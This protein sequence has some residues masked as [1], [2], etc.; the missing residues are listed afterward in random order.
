MRGYVHP[1]YVPSIHNVD[2][3]LGVESL[4]RPPPSLAPGELGRLGRQQLPGA[5]RRLPK[6]GA[7]TKQALPLLAGA[8]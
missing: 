1:Q 4:R 7:P 5:W 8:Q 6:A 2:A 3:S